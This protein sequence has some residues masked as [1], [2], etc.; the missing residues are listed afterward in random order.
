MTRRNVLIAVGVVLVGAAVVAANLW[1]KKSARRHGH[2]RDRQDARSRGDRLGVGQDP[3]EAARSTSA[4]TRVGRVVN[5]AVNE[6]DRVHVGQFLLQIDPKSLRTRVDSGA[7][8]LKTAEETLAQMR[9]STET[10]RAQLE[11]A[12]Q[13][14]KRQQDL[15]G[16][17]LTT[18]EALDKAVNDVKVAESALSER[19]KT[20]DAQ[21]S[22][23]QQERA[24]LDS[25]Q[26]DLSKVRIESPIDGIVTRRNHRRG[27]DGDDRHDEQR[28]HRADDARRHV[29]H[30]G[31]GRG[32]RDQHPERAARPAG[33]GQHRRDPRPDLPRPRRRDRQQPDPGDGGRRPGRRRRRTSRWT[34]SSTSRCRTCAPA[35]RARP[36]SRRPR[37][38]TPWRC[39]FRPW[40]CASSST[41]RT[42]RS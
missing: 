23:I 29:G 3:A 16:Q 17:Q 31:G 21:L 6:G 15:W 12:R 20:A 10:A 26:Y 30:P 1:F 19:Q 42:G 32:R 28:R 4:P 37:A 9:Q 5:L 2:D 18:R 14:L 22:R 41:T 24:S 27:R 7:A 34:S 25:A 38:R 40:R 8:S 36:T 35:S 39:R 33:Q 13:N 11:L